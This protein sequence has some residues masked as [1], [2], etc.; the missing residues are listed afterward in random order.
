MLKKYIKTLA[1]A[2]IMA[3]VFTMFVPVEK[4]EAS[5]GI[6]QPAIYT[7]KI[8]VNLNSS[9]M[10]S[11]TV[12]A[13][14]LDVRVNNGNFRRI[15]TFPGNTSQITITGVNPANEYDIK[16]SCDIHQRMARNILTGQSD[17]YMMQPWLLLLFPD[18]SREYGIATVE[19]LIQYGTSS[20]L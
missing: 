5:S 8:V 12:S 4:T 6:T 13:I 7:N 15:N 10:P 19:T 14:Y 20:R 18:L 2:L 1:M 16:V 17:G 9:G 3:L 11:G